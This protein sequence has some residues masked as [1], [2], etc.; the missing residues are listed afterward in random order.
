MTTT[1]SKNIY[2]QNN[3]LYIMPTLTSEDIGYGSVLDGYTYK[4]SGCTT[5]N[6]TACSV[7]SSNKSYTVINPVQSARISTRGKASLKYGRVEVVAKIP[8]GDW[9]WPAIWMLPVNNTYGNWPMSGEIDVRTL[10]L[11]SVGDKADRTWYS[12]S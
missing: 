1:D 3:E 2:T 5:T 4:L 7:T 10:P 11:C 6:A 9:L 8:T 12:A